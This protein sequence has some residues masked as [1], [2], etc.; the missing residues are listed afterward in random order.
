LNTVL[1][2]HAGCRQSLRDVHERYLLKTEFVRVVYMDFGPGKVMEVLQVLD[3][4]QSPG[5][6]VIRVAPPA[7]VKPPR[8]AKKRPRRR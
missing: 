1:D 5:G 6:L 7:W 3:A 8:P 2:P 4:H